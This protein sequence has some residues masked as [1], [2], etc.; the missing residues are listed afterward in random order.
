VGLQ[1]LQWSDPSFSKASTIACFNKQQQE[2]FPFIIS[3]NYTGKF[4]CVY[5]VQNINIP[6]ALYPLPDPTVRQ[7]TTSN[8]LDRQRIMVSQ[9]NDCIYYYS[10]WFLRHNFLSDWWLGRPRNAIDIVLMLIAL[11]NTARWTGATSSWN[12]HK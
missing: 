6:L 4:A 8:F 11:H 7:T 12:A 2:R 9:I 3:H 1:W 10:L 5:V